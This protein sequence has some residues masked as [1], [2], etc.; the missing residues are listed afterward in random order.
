M[1]RSIRSG[2]RWARFRGYWVPERRKARVTKE[3]GT[4]P[5]LSNS[6]ALAPGGVK[7]GLASAAVCVAFVYSVMMYVMK[8]QPPK[9]P[10][11]PPRF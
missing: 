10:P 1:T 8:A 7:A 5:S 11:R 9:L 3:H 4:L 6:A 2:P